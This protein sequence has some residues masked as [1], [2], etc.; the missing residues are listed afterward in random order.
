MRVNRQSPPGVQSSVPL[1]AKSLQARG[2]KHLVDEML[3]E[4]ERFSQIFEESDQAVDTKCLES[5]E[6]T[7]KSV[8][9]AS[10][11]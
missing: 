11:A 7:E 2:H 4:E 5:K 3:P 6:A 9:R 8:E 1:G 10:A